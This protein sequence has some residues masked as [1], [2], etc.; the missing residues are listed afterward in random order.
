[1]RAWA[2]LAAAC[3]VAAGCTTGGLRQPDA[4]G[5]V[6]L[7]SPLPLL[8]ECAQWY[9][10]EDARVE[11]AGVRDAQ[12]ARLAGFP[13]LRVN[14][15]LASWRVE[16]AASERVL[17]AMVERMHELDIEA[18]RREAANLPTSSPG[19]RDHMAER[20]VMQRA[21]Q[22][23]LLLREADLADPKM[24]AA[25]LAA[26]V[27]P[28]E[29]S[30]A[31]QARAAL[32]Q[33]PAPQAGASVVRYAP[34]PAPP[35][36]R[37][38]VARMIEFA[39]VNPLGIPELNSNELEMLFAAYAPSFEVEIR[40]DE[41]RPGAI[42]WLRGAAMPMVD[43]ADIAVY[44][45]FAWT[46]YRGRVLLQLVY[47]IWFPERRA[48]G[49]GD[50]LAGKLDGFTWRVTLAPDGEPAVYDAVHAS[51]AEHLFFPT[52]R[53][54]PIAVPGVEPFS[55][56]AL[57]RIAER[58]RPVLRIA[59]GTHRL[60]GVSVV[61]GP[62]SLVRYDLRPYDELRSIARLD[63]RRSSMFDPGGEVVGTGRLR[64]WGRQATGFAQPRHF[65]DADLI[66]RRFSI[67]LR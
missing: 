58:E 42:R 51:G 62:D 39:S 67:D 35:L 60:E 25:L 13:Y 1:M 44:R 61:H 52:A 65:D 28:D 43:G 48:S 23:G 20:V 4:H 36:P 21:S 56:Q 54:T 3:A 14:R 15:L 45:R 24:R 38:G 64:Q 19:V 63:G 33:D 46:R 18:R 10:D 7:S 32:L 22:C 50:P 49:E 31:G 34:P 59:A 16:A 27:V 30:Q 37:D 55:S 29:L 47:T 8:R 11:A 66:E 57:P 2:G 9:A 6:H 53:A 26:S 40:G 17:Q 41:D 12:D 5:S